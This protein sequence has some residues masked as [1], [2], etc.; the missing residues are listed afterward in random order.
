MSLGRYNE[1]QREKILQECQRKNVKQRKQNKILFKKKNGL[2]KIDVKVT[3][4]KSKIYQKVL[5]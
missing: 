5:R 2:N 4:K 3:N 1:K